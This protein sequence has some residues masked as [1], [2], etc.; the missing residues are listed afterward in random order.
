MSE[1]RER[2]R[3]GSENQQEVLFRVLSVVLDCRLSTMINWSYFP[4]S[5]P[6]TAFA[7]SVV[8][9]F[10]KVEGVVDSTQFSLK[11]NEVLAAVKPG[12]EALG[13]RVEGGKRDEE[14]IRVPV[15][16]GRNGVLEKAF[17]ADAYHE[18]EGFVVEVEAGRG[19]TNY[20]FLKDL[21]QAC[22]MVDVKHLV[23]AVRNEYKGRQDYEVV[24]RFFGTLYA[25]QRLRLPLNGVLVIGY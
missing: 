2:P 3:V 13:F 19:V 12:L 8:E 24:E 10:V 21:F 6:A 15:L 22:M 17:D 16:F 4:R 11:S 9:A 5:S 7:R 20:Q 25:S 18:Q 1:H 14:R 23:V